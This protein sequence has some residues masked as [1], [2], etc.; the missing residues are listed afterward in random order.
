MRVLNEKKLYKLSA[1]FKTGGFFN[2]NYASGISE[3]CKNEKFLFS[4]GV[5]FFDKR[6]ISSCSFLF[7]SLRFSCFCFNALNC[8]TSTS[9]WVIFLGA[10]CLLLH[11]FSCGA[12]VGSAGSIGMMQAYSFR[13][14]C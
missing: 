8:S 12:F 14:S 10:S 4:S 2:Y 1:S 13:K 6:N 3:L 7:F 5:R 9:A 11:L